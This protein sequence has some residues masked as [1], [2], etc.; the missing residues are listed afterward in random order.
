MILNVSCH[1]PPLMLDFPM[2]FPLLSSDNELAC[3]WAMRPWTAA[4]TA[5]ATAA[6]PD[7]VPRT[8]HDLWWFSF[9]LW[10]SNEKWWLSHEK[11]WFIPL[12]DIATENGHRNG[13]FPIRHGDFPWLCKRL[14]TVYQRVTRGKG[15]LPW[16]RWAMYHDSEIDMD[17]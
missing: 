14:P 12:S 11:L 10:F 4:A 9:S 6:G 13:S 17:L 8:W 1:E 3:H 2:A 5:A 15:G 16:D 7:E